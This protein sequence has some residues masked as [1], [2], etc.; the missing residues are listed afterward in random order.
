MGGVGDDDLRARSITP[1][2]VVRPDHGDAGELTLGA[3]HGGQGYALHACHV[4]EDFLQIVQAGQK[5]LALRLRGERVPTEETGQARGLV[6]APRVVLHGAGT[7]RIKLGIDGEI[8]PGQIGV[9]PDHLQLGDLRQRRRGFAQEGVWDIG[10]H[11]RFEERIVTHHLRRRR[12][13]RLRK[14][15]D[16]AG[17]VGILEDAHAPTSVFSSSPSRSR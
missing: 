17:L 13:A 15:E 5:S 3:S 12:P 10:Q 9:M 16:G 8:L 14:V 6:R 11:F 1:G 2:F 4:G 7:Q